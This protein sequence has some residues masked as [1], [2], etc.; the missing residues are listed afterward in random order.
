MNLHDNETFNG[1]FCWCLFGQDRCGEDV[2][3]LC[4]YVGWTIT[5]RVLLQ[6]VLRS[7]SPIM[8]REQWSS[9]GTKQDSSVPS[10]KRKSKKRHGT[11]GKD[12]GHRRISLG[13]MWAEKARNRENSKIT[14]E[15]CFSSCGPHNSNMCIL[16]SSPDLNGNPVTYV[17][18]SPDPHWVVNHFPR[19]PGWLGGGW[20]QVVFVI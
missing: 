9:H 17:L 10:P 8:T 15:Q 7:K 4:D 20:L 5:L 16:E 14:W 3:K 12:R 1:V 18:T 19:R 13:W 6:C 2:C 11:E